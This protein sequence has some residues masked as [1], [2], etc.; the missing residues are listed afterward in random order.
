MERPKWRPFKEEFEKLKADVARG[1]EK[2]HVPVA[3]P[4]SAPR[5]RRALDKENTFRP[6]TPPPSPKTFVDYSAKALEKLEDEADAR[7]HPEEKA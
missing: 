7:Y 1:A 5:F 4:I 6:K 2:V 3:E